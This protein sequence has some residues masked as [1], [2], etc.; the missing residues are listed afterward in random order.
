MNFPA[1]APEPQLA[2][3]K[4]QQL[5]YTGTNL[6]TPITI[7]VSLF[8]LGFILLGYTVFTKR[9]RENETEEN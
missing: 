8:I 3:E 6:Q 2:A 1:P 4:T 9:K 5:A 7:A